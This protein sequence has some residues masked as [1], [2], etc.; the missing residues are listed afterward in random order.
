MRSLRWGDGNNLFDDQSKRGDL[1]LYQ[2]PVNLVPQASLTLT[3]LFI[4]DTIS[5]GWMRMFLNAT[6]SIISE[7]DTNNYFAQAF[8]G[9]FSSIILIFFIHYFIICHILTL[10]QMIPQILGQELGRYVASDDTESSFYCVKE[11][12]NWLFAKIIPL[13]WTPRYNINVPFPFIK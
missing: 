3:S 10:I 8:L 11:N 12:I 7:K 9:T 2:G 6:K 13:I 1:H 4:Y 5:N